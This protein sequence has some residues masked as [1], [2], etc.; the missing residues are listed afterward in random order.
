MPDKKQTNIRLTEEERRALRMLA[1][2]LGLSVNDWTSDKIAE[3]WER[4]FPGMDFPDKEGKIKPKKG[5]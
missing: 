4:Q 2:A 5:K 3:A 1:G